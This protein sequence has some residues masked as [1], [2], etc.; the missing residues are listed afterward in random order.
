MSKTKSAQPVVQLI[1]GIVQGEQANQVFFIE[2]K[3]KKEK[4][5]EKNQN[6]KIA[7]QI[8][9]YQS[10]Q[11]GAASSSNS[12][13][14]SQSQVKKSLSQGVDPNYFSQKLTL[15]EKVK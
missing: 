13:S 11:G 3:K 10:Q 1:Q 5:K 2:E 7:S 15:D 4:E 14:S 9:E 6:N 8:R 12:S